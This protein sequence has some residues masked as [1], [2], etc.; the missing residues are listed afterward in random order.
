MV[1]SFGTHVCCEA[2]P[3]PCVVYFMSPVHKS[4]HVR[5]SPKH[6]LSLGF[7]FIAIL[8]NHHFSRKFAWEE[9][10]SCLGNQRFEI[11]VH[12]EH[13]FDEIQQLKCCG[14]CEIPCSGTRTE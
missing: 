13:F 5:A 12:D 14:S 4:I 9:I 1:R 10:I 2:F 3:S 11:K 8:A 7:G 6:H